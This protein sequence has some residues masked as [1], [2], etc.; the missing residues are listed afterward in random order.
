VR[1]EIGPI[2]PPNE[3]D[4]LLVRFTRNCPWNKCAFC[5]TF[6]NNDFEKRTVP[7]IKED[8][9]IIRKIRDEIVALSLEKGFNGSVTDDL[10][11]LIFSTPEHN[12]CFTS[13]AIW[14]YF[15]GK[16]VF[17]QD[18]NSLAVKPEDFIEALTYLKQQLPSI[19]RVTSY[20]RSRTVAKRLAID[21]LVKMQEAGLTRLHIGLETGSDFL[22]KYM[23]KGVTKEEHV[24]CGRKVKEAGIEL[25][26]YVIPGLG[27]KTW[28]KEHIRETADALKII[29]PDFIRLRTLKIFRTMPLYQKVKSND[30]VLLHEEEILMEIKSLIQ[31]LDGVTSCIKSDHIFNLLEDIDGKLPGDKERILSVIDSYFS[32]SQEQRLVYRFG[33]RAGEYRSVGDLQDK[34]TYSHIDK[35]IRDIEEKNP[36]SIERTVS[37]LFEDQI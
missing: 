12:E 9:D 6:K 18:A 2:R 36:G 25:S 31:K 20:A 4:S 34:L 24:E 28:S 33:R 5:R 23:N 8:I 7:E 21:D 27:G 29:N 30:F 19:E 13:V 22:L 1:Y 15:G 11:D 3:A 10:I 14:L 16:N 32:L 17:I 26:E 37:H 35:T